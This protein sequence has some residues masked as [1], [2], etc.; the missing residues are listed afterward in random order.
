MDERS[1]YNPRAST[2]WTRLCGLFGSEAV[3]RKFGETPPPEWVAALSRLTDP[4]IERGLRRL[5]YSGA[6][7]VPT[8][9]EFMKFA[10]TVGSQ[11]QFAE[12]RTHAALPAPNWLGDPWE[13]TAN[14][15]LLAFVLREWSRLRIPPGR[16]AELTAV[17]VH[18]KRLWAADMREL[19]GTR[20]GPVDVAT[21][22]RTWAEYVDGV[23]AEIARVSA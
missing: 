8:L 19:A 3:A 17:A 2:V 16:N 9:P 18:A 12:P 15:H 22:K 13:Q 6:A 10:R 5:V 7:H 11:E 21:Q 14:S 20:D 23:R 4:E 1:T